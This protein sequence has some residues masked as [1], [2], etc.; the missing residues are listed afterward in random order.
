MLMNNIMIH[1][2]KHTVSR[3]IIHLFFSSFYRTKRSLESQHLLLR[4]TYCR[5]PTCA[6][7]PMTI[8]STAFSTTATTSYVIFFLHHLRHH[9]TTLCDPGDITCNSQLAS[10]HSLTETFYIECSTLTHTEIFY[11]PLYMYNVAFCQLFLILN[12]RW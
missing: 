10:L 1:S 9:N 3:K 12:E 2:Y 11:H 6:V 4:Q 8:C 5:S 7:K